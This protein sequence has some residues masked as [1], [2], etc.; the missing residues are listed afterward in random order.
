MLP[1]MYMI[2]YSCVAVE[3]V[4]SFVCRKFNAE[5]EKK[6]GKIEISAVEDLKIKKEEEKLEVEEEVLNTEPIASPDP[7]NS[8]LEVEEEPQ[9]LPV[10][11]EISSFVVGDGKHILEKTPGRLPSEFLRNKI[12]I[13]E[14]KKMM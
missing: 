7:E 10:P 1:V 11:T 4:K 9:E 13:F 2:H 8:P 12:M 6:Y 5:M 3:S 14:P